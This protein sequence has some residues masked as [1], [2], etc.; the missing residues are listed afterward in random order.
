MKILSTMSSCSLRAISS[1]STFT[2]EIIVNTDV[3]DIERC[4]LEGE[5][6]HEDQL[7]GAGQQVPGEAWLG[8]AGGAW[9]QLGGG[10]AAGGDRGR[11]HRQPGQRY[12]AESYNVTLMYI[13]IKIHYIKYI[14]RYIHGIVHFNLSTL[15][16]K[17][18]NTTRGSA[19]MPW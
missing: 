16:S 10:A 7:A 5:Q 3:T 14:I 11:E 15:M 9:R 17:W 8:G 2:T 4:H 6:Y 12:L 1:T 18:E 13:I 19:V